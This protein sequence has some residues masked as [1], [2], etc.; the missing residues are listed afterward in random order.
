M[1]AK[2]NRAIFVFTKE[3]P[4]QLKPCLAQFEFDNHDIFVIDDSY[5]KVNIRS[6]KEII[7][8][9]KNVSYLGAEENEEFYFKYKCKT[10]LKSKIGFIKW[11]LG[12]ARNFAIDFAIEMGFEKILFLDDDILFK[13]SLELENGFII[14]NDCNFISYKITG[15]VD[16]SIV[17]HI[18]NRFEYM[19]SVIRML[20]GGVFYLKPNSLKYRFVNIYNEDWIIQLLE[21]EKEKILH[22]TEVIHKSYNPFCNYKEKVL[23]QEYGEI[24]VK[25]LIEVYRED[26]DKTLSIDFWERILKE[27]ID[28][29]RDLTHIA[30]ELKEQE[31]VTILIWLMKNYKHYNGKYFCNLMHKIIKRKYIKDERKDYRIQ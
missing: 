12:N 18:A 28:Y 17:G 21:F 29:L 23:F 7:R 25:G 5:S 15:M 6:N 24:F 1:S 2:D 31:F 26:L 3:S 14:L 8:N 27:R 10:V 20:S 16:D 11:N 19:N 13:N 9:V 22:T 30:N 4:Q